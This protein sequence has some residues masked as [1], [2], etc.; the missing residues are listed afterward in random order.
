[1]HRKMSLHA[2][3]KRMGATNASA[4][5]TVLLRVAPL[6]SGVVVGQ[7]ASSPI[8]TTPTHMSLAPQAIHGSVPQEGQLAV[9]PQLDTGHEIEAT[10]GSPVE[11]CVVQFVPEITVV[12]LQA[13]PMFTAF[14]ARTHSRVLF[15][16]HKA[17]P[18]PSKWKRIDGE[19]ATN[20]P[21]MQARPTFVTAIFLAK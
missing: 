3:S 7:R 16:P 14:A 2:T 13:M 9:V 5:K 19:C 10:L 18:N 6:V 11:H 17:P 15:Q 20:T 4:A 21:A 12:S 8:L 1:M